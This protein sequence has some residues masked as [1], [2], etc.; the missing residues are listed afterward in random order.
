[1]NPF[2]NT[3]L[4][5]L[6]GGVRWGRGG[7]EAGVK[8]EMRRGWGDDEEEMRRGMGKGRENKAGTGSCGEHLR[9]GIQKVRDVMEKSGFFLPVWG[10]S[11]VYITGQTFYFL[12]SVLN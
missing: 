8:G 9:E 4:S 12:A 11:L 7:G 5:A 6:V 2:W 3:V 10:P 1:M